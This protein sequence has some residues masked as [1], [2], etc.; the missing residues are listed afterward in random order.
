MEPVRADWTWPSGCTDELFA[1]SSGFVTPVRAQHHYVD[2]GSQFSSRNSTPR[3]GI[4]AS[5]GATF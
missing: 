5:F 3:R 2:L 4:F 1:D